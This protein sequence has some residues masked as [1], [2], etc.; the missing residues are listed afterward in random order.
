MS[1]MVFILKINNFNVRK[2][3]KIENYIKI[4]TNCSWHFAKKSLSQRAVSKVIL[5][6]ISVYEKIIMS[7]LINL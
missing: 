2:E 4:A 7:N 3:N 6:M 1:E 5:K